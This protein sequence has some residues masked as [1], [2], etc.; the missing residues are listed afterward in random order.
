[1]GWAGHVVRI[2][3]DRKAYRVLVCKPEGKVDLGDQR[4]RWENRVKLCHKQTG[5]AGAD[6]TN[7]VPDRTR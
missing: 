7:L 1:V 6:W 3:N 5:W 4:F 2:E